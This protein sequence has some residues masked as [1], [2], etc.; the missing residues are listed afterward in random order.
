MIVVIHRLDDETLLRL[1]GNEG[2]SAIAAFFYARDGVEPQ[3][4]FRLVRGAV[5]FVATRRENRADGF[6]KE[7]VAR[8]GMSGEA[9]RE[10]SGEKESRSH[11]S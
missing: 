4:A 5:T 10:R 11:A 9:E 3:P 7:V 6:F 8:T 1:T 2:R